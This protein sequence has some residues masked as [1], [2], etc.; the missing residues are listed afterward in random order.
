MIDS[1]VQTVEE[2]EGE[3]CGSEDRTCCRSEFVVEKLLTSWLSVC[4]YGHLTQHVAR[5]LFLLYNAIK[6]QTDK[7]PVDA[8]TS[9]ARY[10]L[11]EDRLLRDNTHY[12]PLV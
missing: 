8:V 5:P 12:R 7:G 1:V 4:M 11:S 3:R 9:D 6:H 2:R 10:A